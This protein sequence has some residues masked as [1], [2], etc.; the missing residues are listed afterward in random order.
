MAGWALIA[1]AWTLD[2]LHPGARAD[3]AQVDHPGPPPSVRERT[4]AAALGLQP[5]TGHHPRHPS[6]RRDIADD[7]I[8]SLEQR[9]PAWAGR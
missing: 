7:V 5:S 1:F 4:L 9:E 8:A 2:R 6:T 3:Y